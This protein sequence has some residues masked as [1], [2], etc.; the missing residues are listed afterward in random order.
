MRVFEERYSDG[1]LDINV[2]CLAITKDLN[3]QASSVLFTCDNNFLQIEDFKNKNDPATQEIS[4]KQQLNGSFGENGIISN[5]GKK[6]KR[7][8]S[9]LELLAQE[10]EINS[11]DN[12]SRSGSHSSSSVPSVAAYSSITDLRSFK[13]L[14]N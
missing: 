14:T 5:G 2:F 10:Q 3:R 1:I 13:M 11:G 12:N 7:H 9:K 4:R 6:E 8:F